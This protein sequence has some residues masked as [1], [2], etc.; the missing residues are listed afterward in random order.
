MT[1]PL[2]V[3][4]TGSEG[5]GKTTLARALAERYRTIWV[6]EAARTRAETKGR[7]LDGTDVE[8]I[9]RRHVEDADAAVSLAAGLLVLDTDLVST[10]VYARHYYGGCP[11]WIEREARARRG[12]IYLLH[13]PDVPWVPDGVRDRG[14]SRA[15]MHASFVRMLASLDAR[16]ADVRGAWAERERHA[17]EAIEALLVEAGDPAGG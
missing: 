5:T 1:R 13:R 6:P 2:R 9:A 16:V 7:P 4:L 12:D 8:W 15:A 11:V 17:V 14:D 3:V 10:V